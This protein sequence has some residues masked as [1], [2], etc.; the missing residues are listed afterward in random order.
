MTVTNYSDEKGAFAYVQ[1][2]NSRGDSAGTELREP[3]YL[4]YLAIQRTQRTL[5]CSPTIVLRH[6]CY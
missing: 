1:K 4:G 3:D 5:G 6:L 2:K